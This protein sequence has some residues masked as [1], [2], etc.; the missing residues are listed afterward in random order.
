MSPNYDVNFAV[1][2]EKLHRYRPRTADLLVTM[3]ELCASE[4]AYYA[5]FVFIYL[6]VWSEAANRKPVQ[7]LSRSDLEDFTFFEVVQDNEKALDLFDEL[8]LCYQA[9]E[10]E[11]KTH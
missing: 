3:K 2:H 5:G 1:L 6:R 9:E 4:I 10:D 11:S 8:L 7:A